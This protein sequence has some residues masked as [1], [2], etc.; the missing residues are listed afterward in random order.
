ML[1]RYVRLRPIIII[2]IIIISKFIKRHVCL[3]KAAEAHGMNHLSVCL[4]VYLSV[5][6][7][8]CTLGR[9]LNVT[10]IFSHRLITHRLGQFVLKFW[11]KIRR[12]SIICVKMRK[13]LSALLMFVCCC[14]SLF[15]FLLAA[16]SERIKMYTGHRAS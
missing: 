1:L 2:I 11:A 12:G 15:V 7:V 14:L 4:S 13:C 16:L 10:A 3:Q 5:C 8:C 9:D 6:N